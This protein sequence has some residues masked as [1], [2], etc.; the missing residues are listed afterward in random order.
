MNPAVVRKS[1]DGVERHGENETGVVDLRIKY[2]IRIA[3]STG[4]DAV[5]V[6]GPGPI[7]DIAGPDGNRARTKDGSPLTHGHI[8]RRR[9]SKD[10]QQEQKDERQAEI[11]LEGFVTARIWAAG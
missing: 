5:I 9:G 4:R 1:S 8:C 10:G 3:R 11:H 7:D 2:S 6:A